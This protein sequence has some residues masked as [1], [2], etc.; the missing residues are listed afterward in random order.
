MKKR[1]IVYIDVVNGD[2]PADRPD[3]D[4]HGFVCPE[5]DIKEPLQSPTNRKDTSRVPE[6]VDLYNGN[7]CC[8]VRLARFRFKWFGLQTVV[9]SWMLSS[10]IPNTLLDSSRAFVSWIKD[11]Y[12]MSIEDMRK[13]E[14]QIAEEQRGMKFEE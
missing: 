14:E 3:W 11:W 8:I 7:I 2:P 9:E 13:Y 6:W 12:P 4:L 5:A 1:R 10:C